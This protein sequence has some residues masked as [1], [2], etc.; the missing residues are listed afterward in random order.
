M[1]I[2]ILGSTGSIGTSTLEVV[3]RNPENYQVVA[4]AAGQNETL[5][6]EQIELFRPSVVC[7]SDENAAS[8][9]RK[10]LTGVG[11]AEVVSGIEGLKKVATLD[12]VDIVVAAI[13]GS[14][15]L[16]P[17]FA[18]V[19][20]GKTIALANKETLVMAGQLI[21]SV[22]SRTGAKI[23]PVDSEHSAIY[24]LLDKQNRDDIRHIILTASGGPFLG[25]K[26]EDL[27]MVSPEEALNHPR[28]KMGKKVT[29]DSASLMNKSLEIIEAHWLFKLP[30]ERIKV[31]IH[32]QSIIHSMVEFVDGT[33]FAQL[34]H[35][36]MKGPIAYALSC[37]NRISDTVEPLDLTRI[38]ELTFIEPDMEAFPALK[39]AYRALKEEG[40]MPT[41]MNAVNEVAVEQ[42]HEGRIRFSFIP[43][44]IEKVMNMFSC[45][46]AL[47]LESIL[48]VDQ[49]ARTEACKLLEKT[50]HKEL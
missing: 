15:G 32:P 49:W 4:L 33:V 35:P 31:V 1:K 50:E 10:I 2:S 20:A 40:L 39:L 45:D 11:K 46:S 8:R 22:A 13:S 25:Y 37:P 7:L 27:D 38:R 3:K 36:D 17:T 48:K 41:V 6:A 21:T 47:N 16:I 24:Q 14:Q 29:T 23:I 43:V 26:K 42:F 19:E 28:W 30:G 12:S 44:L 18:A 34:S 9:L 5:L